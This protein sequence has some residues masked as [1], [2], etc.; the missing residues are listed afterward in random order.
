MGWKVI[1]APTL[2]RAFPKSKKKI[3]TFLLLCQ[4]RAERILFSFHLYFFSSLR[5][6]SYCRSISTGDHLRRKEIGKKLSDETSSFVACHE[7]IVY[8][9]VIKLPHLIQFTVRLYHILFLVL[10]CAYFSC[11]FLS[12]V[13]WLVSRLDATR[14]ENMKWKKKYKM[15]MAKSHCEENWKKRNLTSNLMAYARVLSFAEIN[16]RIH[17]L[18]WR[19]SNARYFIEQ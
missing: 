19:K 18:L 5:F 13:S 10:A 14:R 3:E 15:K 7:K 12:L 2:W 1:A 8:I 11:I 4:W 17:S 16:T 9:K 6:L